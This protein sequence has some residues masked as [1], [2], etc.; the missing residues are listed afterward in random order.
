[1]DKAVEQA[2]NEQINAELYSAYLYLSISAWFSSIGMKGMAAW[3]LVQAQEERDHAMMLYN[4]LLSSGGK[5]IATEIKAP[6]TEWGSPKEAFEF[7]LAHEKGVTASINRLI[8]ISQS[9][10]DH[11]SIA[12]LQWFITEQVEEEENVRDVL[13]QITLAADF[14]SYLYMIDK[15]LGTRVY[16]PPTG[17]GA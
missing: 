4:Y 13:N 9:A 7:Q 11:A 15:E 6:Q 1:M 2:L 10:K 17:N 5:M 16:T 3:E 14:P 12:R 8:E